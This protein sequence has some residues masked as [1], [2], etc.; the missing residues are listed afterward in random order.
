MLLLACLRS[1]PPLSLPCSA[2]LPAPTNDPARYAGR[3]KIGFV[4]PHPLVTQLQSRAVETELHFDVQALPT[5]CPPLPWTSPRFGGYVLIPTTLMR[6]V[7]MATQHQNL[8]DLC[9]VRPCT[10]FSA[11]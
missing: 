2:S 6:S 5:S 9:Q 3:L 1:A 8:L 7:D 11:A 4:K 10:P